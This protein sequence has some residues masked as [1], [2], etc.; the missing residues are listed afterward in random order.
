MA[1]GYQVDEAMRQ[2]PSEKHRRTAAPEEE[3]PRISWPEENAVAIAER[4]TRIEIYGAPLADLQ[5]L[6][7]D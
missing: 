6:N 4:H 7:V 5:V 3:D 2:V 1:A